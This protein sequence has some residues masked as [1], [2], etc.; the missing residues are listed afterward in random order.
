MC[1]LSVELNATAISPP[2]M[3]M[4]EMFNILLEK[5]S[6]HTTVIFTYSGLIAL[7]ACFCHLDSLDGEDISEDLGTYL[8]SYLCD[9]AA[10]TGAESIYSA[11]NF[12]YSTGCGD[13]QWTNC[14]L[15]AKR[16][17]ALQNAPM[18]RSL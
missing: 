13:T 16:S 14:E 15:H 8:S 5:L 1:G 3:K 17:L 2:E 12:L 6:I 10:T 4:D 7:H 9:L 11:L 18:S